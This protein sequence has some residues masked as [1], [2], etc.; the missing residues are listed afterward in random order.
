[1][2]ADSETVH[3]DVVDEH[4]IHIIV[5][6][7]TVPAGGFA[8]GAAQVEVFEDITLVVVC[9]STI[10]EGKSVTARSP[11]E[12]RSR[13]VARGPGWD[14][15]AYCARSGGRTIVVHPSGA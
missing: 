14:V 11:P 7:E 4:I 6:K 8:Y 15:V 1:M 9:I 2:D 5:Q 12:N 13:L 10:F 3:P